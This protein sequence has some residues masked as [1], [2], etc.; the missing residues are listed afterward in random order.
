M[1]LESDAEG[2]NTLCEP[3]QA[4]VQLRQGPSNIDHVKLLSPIRNTL[5]FQLFSTFCGPGNISFESGT[6][7]NPFRVH[8]LQ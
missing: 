2:E 3:V 8:Y 4:L 1:Y 6:R 7:S 5:I